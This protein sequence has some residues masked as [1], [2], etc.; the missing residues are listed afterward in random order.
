MYLQGF[1][2]KRAYAEVWF[3]G[4]H[5]QFLCLLTVLLQRERLRYSMKKSP[6]D[7]VRVLLFTEPNEVV[8]AAT[9]PSEL[10]LLLP[11]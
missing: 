10:P 5:Q 11:S 7:I 8:H 9:G 4:A 6:L 2:P 1:I 3:A